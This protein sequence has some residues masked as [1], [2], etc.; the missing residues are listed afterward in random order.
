M[1]LK[2]NSKS[3]T[4]CWNPAHPVARPGREKRT[5]RGSW[6]HSAPPRTAETLA[7]HREKGTAARKLASLTRRS[8]VELSATRALPDFLPE[9]ETYPRVQ[10]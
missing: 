8:A 9:K 3:W 5:M 1:T 2:T 4:N 7:A 10:E 6:G